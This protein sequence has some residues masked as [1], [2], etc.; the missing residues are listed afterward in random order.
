[1]PLDHEL[2]RRLTE[3]LVEEGLRP[4]ASLAA[5]DAEEESHSS[6]QSERGAAAQ[7]ENGLRVTGWRWWLICFAV[8]ASCSMYGL[9]TTIVADVQGAVTDTFDNVAQIAW[10]GAG[11]LLGS[12]VTILPYGAPSTLSA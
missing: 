5:L 1:V 4:R 6:S 2:A 11:F 7:D 8:Y 3:V 10:L 9:D 12:T